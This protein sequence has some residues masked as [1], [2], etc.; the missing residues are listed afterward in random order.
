MMD[1]RAV[2]ASGYS[3]FMIGGIAISLD[4]DENEVLQ[5]AAKEL[6]R[7]GIN[8]ARLNLS[9]YIYDLIEEHPSSKFRNFLLVA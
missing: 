6:R 1:K 5:L 3:I 2:Q 7:A 9:I 8:P 4:T